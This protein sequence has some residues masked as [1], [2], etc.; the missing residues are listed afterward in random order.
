M[1][2]LSALFKS[3]DRLMCSGPVGILSF[4]VTSALWSSTFQNYYLFNV[5][6]KAVKGFLIFVLNTIVMAREMDF[7]KA[8]DKDPIHVLWF[9]KCIIFEEVKRLRLMCMVYFGEILLERKG[10]QP[11]FGFLVDWLCGLCSRPFTRSRTFEVGKVNSFIS[12]S[13]STG[14]NF[15]ID[16]GICLRT[17]LGVVECTH[18]FFQTFWR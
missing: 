3:L 2:V 1:S 13:V 6:C 14:F 10:N 9:N 15:L 5:G 11:M 16:N 17:D 8:I 7:E 18:F 4:I 12:F